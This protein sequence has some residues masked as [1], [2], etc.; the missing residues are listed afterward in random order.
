MVIHTGANSTDTAAELS[1]H[2]RSIAADAVGII[3]PAY[4]RLDEQALFE[5][6]CAVA[7]EV[8]GFPAFL[9]NIPAV[10]GNDVAPELLL[11]VVRKADN[12]IGLKYSCDNLPRFREYRKTM[13]AS[14]ALFIGD[15]SLALPALYEGAS[16]VVS[17]NSSA[18]PDL[19]VRLYRLYQAGSL[20]EAAAAQGALDEFIA[21]VDHSAELSTF[22]QILASRGVAVGEV[23]RPLKRLSV[24]A[25]AALRLG[26]RRLEHRG[27][28]EAPDRKS[29]S[30]RAR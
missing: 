19:L 2:A 7:R 23:R 16:G 26:I 20:A 11:R 18:V 15:D 12:V 27:L 10:T 4:Y 6:F 5:H 21:S 13:G 25:R 9:Y 22:K 28:L 29:A 3:S 1:V 30:R 8:R 24:T 14:F 17:G